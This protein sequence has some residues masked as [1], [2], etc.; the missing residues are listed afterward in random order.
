MCSE[1][2]YGAGLTVCVCIYV[3]E[4]EGD[5]ETEKETEGE[6][7]EICVYVTRNGSEEK[8]EVRSHI[9]YSVTSVFTLHVYALL[10]T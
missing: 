2:H 10:G 8:T 7:I 9:L 1:N 6:N 4:R 5:R 3:C